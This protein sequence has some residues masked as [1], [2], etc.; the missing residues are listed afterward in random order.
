MSIGYEMPKALEVGG[1]MI[2]IRYD[3]RAVLDI[4]S[5][6]N[7][8]DLRGQG[9][10][11]AVIKIFYPDWRYAVEHADEAF[12]KAM[13][14]INGGEDINPNEKPKPVLMDWEQDFKLIVAPINRTLGYECREAESLHWWTFLSAYYEIGEC[15]FATVVSLRNKQKNHKKLEKWERD[16]IRENADLVNIKKR[17]DSTTQVEIDEIL[18]N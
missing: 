6:I 18:G 16:F 1:K 4:I 5:A 17:Y 2:D 3:F 13:W 10:I 12:N 9:V 7:D 14:F 8:P 11:I 15:L